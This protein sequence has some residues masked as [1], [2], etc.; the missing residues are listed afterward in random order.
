M[1]RGVC[2]R[3]I[4][5]QGKGGL[6]CCSPPWPP[7]EREQPAVVGP[8]SKHKHKHKHATKPTR[9]IRRGAGVGSRHRHRSRRRI[10]ATCP[11]IVGRVH[12]PYTRPGRQA[13]G[14]TM[15]QPQQPGRGHGRQH[16]RLGRALGRRDVPPLLS[17]S[18][19][20][21]CT[22]PNSKP[23]TVGVVAPTTL[24]RRNVTL[25]RR[26]HHHRSQA[27]PAGFLLRARRSRRHQQGFSWWHSTPTPHC[28][29]LGPRKR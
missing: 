16:G 1:V 9:G 23:H 7:A 6:H 15:K 26:R 19:R 22:C 11:N 13:V 12:C 2:R 10:C 28:T 24:W 14:L 17:S 5:W 25:Q 4:R 29:W 20:R 27:S 18:P 8:E 21:P 3:A